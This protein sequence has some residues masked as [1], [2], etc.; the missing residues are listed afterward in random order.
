MTVGQDSL[1]ARRTF[2]VGGKRY[3]YFSIAAA[4]DAGLG[5]VS[6]LPFSLKVL[7]E[8]LLRYED[9]RSVTVLVARSEITPY[10]A[11]L[12]SRLAGRT[13]TS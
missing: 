11:D 4:Q 5:D 8:N 7:L 10:D 12:S 9:G 3:D 1:K 6:R 13:H 2:D